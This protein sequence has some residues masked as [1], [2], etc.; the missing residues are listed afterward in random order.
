MPH[1]H[2][3]M[4]GADH[5]RRVHVGFLAL[6]QHHV[7][8]ADVGPALLEEQIYVQCTRLRRIAE[9]AGVTLASVKAHG[10]LYHAAHRDE[11]TAAA[12]V[13]GIV[14]AVGAIAIVGPSGGALEK[15]LESGLPHDELYLYEDALRREFYGF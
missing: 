14:R 5:L 4:P 15:E 12:C 1:D 9:R 8:V 2:A 10:A 11:V 13:D 3:Q 7:A 6:G